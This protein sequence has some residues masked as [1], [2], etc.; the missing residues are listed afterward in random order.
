MSTI[1]TTKHVFY[2]SLYENTAYL[3]DPTLYTH[4]LHTTATDMFA[5]M[6]RDYV[7]YP[8]E[9]RIFEAQQ[10]I[11]TLRCFVACLHSP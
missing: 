9:H 8:R 3:E 11:V 10:K 6:I 4:V 1:P 5:P 7:T 2:I